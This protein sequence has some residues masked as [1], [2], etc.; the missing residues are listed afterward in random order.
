MTEPTPILI[1][2]HIPKNAGT[3]LSRAIKL[4]LLGVNPL[5]WAHQA[6][7]LGHYAVHPWDRRAEAITALPPTRR[8]RVRFFEAHC[9]FGVHE[10]LGGPHRYMTVLREPVD[11]A[12]S[13]YYHLREE[14]HI[15]PDEPLDAFI[16]R[17]NP[18]GR[19]WRIDNAQ[20]RYLAGEA[21]VIDD[22]P[23]E[24]CDRAMLQTA[25]DR[26]EHRIDHLLVQ[27]R[28]DE[29]VVL[30][31]HRLGWPTLHYARSNTTRSRRSVRDTD[32]VLLDRLAELNRLDTELYRF[33]RDLFDRRADELA[34]E[35][36]RPLEELLTRF[37]AGN[38]RYAR[39]TGPIY[40]MIPARRERRARRKQRADRDA[41][42]DR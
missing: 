41:P 19:V 12:L 22:R 42:D 24:A 34:H 14:G 32:P 6:D 13:V 5:R 35:L 23:P 26:L 7:I 18:A 39:I 29:G 3:T 33:A 9:G 10:R 25:I 28:F 40:A 1:H 21:G 11:R 36:G 37:R 27:D 38:S 17:D 8:R 4:R 2:L 31:A 20:T 16:A 30:L 15:R